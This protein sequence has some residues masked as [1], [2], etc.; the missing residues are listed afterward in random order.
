MLLT[1]PASYQNAIWLYGYLSNSFGRFTARQT[2]QGQRLCV[3]SSGCVS[4][5]RLLAG[6][7]CWQ[8]RHI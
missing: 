3:N 8:G 5:C 4:Q 1:N 7:N 6:H 2:L